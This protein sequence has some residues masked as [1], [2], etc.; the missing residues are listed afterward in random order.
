MHNRDRLE[1]NTS[2][3]TWYQTSLVP[4]CRIPIPFDYLTPY[5]QADLPTEYTSY[6]NLLRKEN[7]SPPPDSL[8]TYPLRLK[9]ITTTSHFVTENGIR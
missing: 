2:A 4:N 6:S 9:T 7:S 1:N 3:D 5:I 8:W